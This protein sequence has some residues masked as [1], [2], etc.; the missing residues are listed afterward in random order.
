MVAVPPASLISV[1]KLCCNCEIVVAVV[2]GV[3]PD[4]AIDPAVASVCDVLVVDVDTEDAVDVDELADE[5]A[6]S[7]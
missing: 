7:S 5:L 6:P 1:P 3:E 4:E 2:V